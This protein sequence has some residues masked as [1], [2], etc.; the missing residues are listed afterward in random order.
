MSDA[1]GDLRNG[2]VGSVGGIPARG[3]HSR[4]HALAM[5]GRAGCDSGRR[6]RND[7]VADA[8]ALPYRVHAGLRAGAG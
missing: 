4:A 6:V 3:R 1:V 5:A 8:D 2:L 7:S